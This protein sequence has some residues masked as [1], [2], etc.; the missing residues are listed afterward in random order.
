MKNYRKILSMYILL[1][2][3]I[4]IVNYLIY[5]INYKFIK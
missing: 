3:Q 2:F 4:Y 1:N 5:K